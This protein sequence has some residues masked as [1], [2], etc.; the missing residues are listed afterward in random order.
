MTALPP[1]QWVYGVQMN[2]IRP[3]FFYIQ[4][5]QNILDSDNV[6]MINSLE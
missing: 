3:F 2:T 4:V 1:S 5:S 6:H